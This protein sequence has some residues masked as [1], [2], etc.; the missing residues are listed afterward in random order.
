LLAIEIYLKGKELNGVGEEKLEEE[1]MEESLLHFVL[2]LET[3]A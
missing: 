1:L 2:H 3:A